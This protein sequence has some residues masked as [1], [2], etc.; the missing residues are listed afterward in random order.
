MISEGC[1]ARF[2][3]QYALDDGSLVLGEIGCL[4]RAA[5]GRTSDMPATL[6]VI[7]RI[8]RS[9]TASTEIKELRQDALVALQRNGALVVQSAGLSYQCEACD[10]DCTIYARALLQCV[11]LVLESRRTFTPWS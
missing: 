7:H 8:G 4:E 2:G 1:F 3:D 9:A 5:T 10:S 11:F 6:D